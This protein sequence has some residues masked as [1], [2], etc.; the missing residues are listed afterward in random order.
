M[1]WFLLDIA[2][3]YLSFRSF[4]VN[5]THPFHSFYGINLNQN[6]VLGQIGF[7]GKSGT[8]WNRLFKISTGN[9]II[10]ALGFVPGTS[11]SLYY[12]AP[13]SSECIVNRLL[14]FNLDYRNLGT[15]VDPNPRILNGRSF[16]CVQS[17]SFICFRPFHYELQ[18]G[19]LAGK[20]H[21]LSKGAFIICF[22]FLQFF[23]NF[24]ANT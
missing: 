3:A 13:M 2:Y 4:R 5:G 24:G 19:V 11:A 10:T 14:C 17:R 23:F 8:E 16:P 22:A 7:D 20:F 6:V 15:K 9:L 12:S 1:C 21:E 18:V